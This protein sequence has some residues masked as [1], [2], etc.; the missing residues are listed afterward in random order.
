MQGL[1]KRR[2]MSAIRLLKGALGGLAALLVCLYPFWAWWGLERFGIFPVALVL[3]VV[4]A[5]KAMVSRSPKNL[6]FAAIAVL[7]AALSALLDAEEPMLFYPVA[8]NL[9]L[10][11][12]FGSS[13]SATPIVE[14]FARLRTPDLPPEGV[15]WCRGVTKVWCGF[16]IANGIAALAT[17]LYGDREIWMLWNGCASYVLIGVLFAGEFLLRKISKGRAGRKR[18]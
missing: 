8:V 11:W 3:A 10:L 17:V 9:F 16:F 5:L 2:G 1:P 12:L 13:L 7:R 4:M 14:K 18:Q 15:R 6:G